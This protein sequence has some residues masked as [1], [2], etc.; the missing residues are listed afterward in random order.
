MGFICKYLIVD[1]KRLD[2]ATRLHEFNY[3]KTLTLSPSLGIQIHTYIV[4]DRRL[5]WHHNVNAQNVWQLV[6]HN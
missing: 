4:R 1:I 3:Q 2:T 6:R 5:I